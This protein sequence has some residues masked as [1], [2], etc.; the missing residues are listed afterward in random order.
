MQELSLNILD[1]AQN[2]IR[3]GASLISISV[4]RSVIDNKMTIIIEDNGC[5]MSEEKIKQV[6]N[7]FFTTRTTRSVGLGVPFF[8]MSAEMT[9]GDFHIESEE[10]VGTTVTATYVLNHIDLMP[11]GDMASTMVSLISVNPE[12]D[13]TYRYGYNDQHFILDTREVKKVLEGVPIN[14]PEVLIFMK[15]F[16]EENTKQIEK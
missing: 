12:I 3:A 16:I 6:T 15:E 5:G 7:P 13:F 9:G 4:L 14:A 8:K 11:L 10:G 1:I 2:S